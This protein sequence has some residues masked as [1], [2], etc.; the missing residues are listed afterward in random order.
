MKSTKFNLEQIRQKTLKNIDK[1]LNE[2]ALIAVAN[3]KEI[4]L[5]NK[6]YVTGT[7]YKSVVA[8]VENLTLEFGS[9]VDYAKT[10]ETGINVN[11]P[12]VNDIRDWAINKVRLGHADKSLIGFSKVIA[13]KIS[14]T[15]RIKNYTPFM[16]PSF[17]KVVKIIE[18]KLKNAIVQE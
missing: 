1:I 3:A 6:H 15:G 14:N 13:N 10:I 12:S 9:N 11:S 5:N 7:L 16:E 2:G 17:D 8:N 18:P 4:L